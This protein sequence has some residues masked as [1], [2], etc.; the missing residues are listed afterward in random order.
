[1]NNPKAR[2]EWILEE[3]KINPVLGFS[4]L[5]SKYLVKFSKSEVTYSK[6][7]NKANERLKSYQDLINNAK[8]EQSIE[9]EKEA[10]KRDILT[11]FEA[12]EILTDIAKSENEKSADR[13]GAIETLAKF[14]GWNV[15]IK[16]DVSLVIPVLNIDPLSDESDNSTTED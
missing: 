3:L 2:Q 7:W 15:A 11:K 8:L 10:V 13:K 6:D 14:E 1:M 16:N 5:F 12:M 4:E 9:T